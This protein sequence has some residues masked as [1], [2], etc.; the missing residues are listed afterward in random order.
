MKIRMHIGLILYLAHGLTLA[1]RAQPYLSDHN[2]WTNSRTWVLGAPPQYFE[3]TY[4]FVSGDSVVNTTVYKKIFRSYRYCAN[5]VWVPGQ[6]SPC[7][8]VPSSPVLA[9]LIREVGPRWYALGS[10]GQDS[11]LYRFDL[12]VGDSVRGNNPPS[13]FVVDTIIT[14]YNQSGRKLFQVRDTFNTNS[15]IS[16]QGILEG[17]GPT[18]GFLS[19]LF[20]Q[21]FE[22]VEELM[23]YSALP[24]PT[25]CPWFYYLGMGQ[26]LEKE[27]MLLYPNPST[28]ELTIRLF[29]ISGPSVVYL[30]DASG[31]ILFE[32]DYSDSELHLDM[33]VY[34]EGLYVVEVKTPDRLIRRK[35]VKQN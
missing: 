24:M 17:I 25:Y 12:A 20:F 9:A 29:D 6:N 8:A 28:R 1:L 14:N 2:I 26:Y 11:L 27:Q 32:R 33:K 23:C 21:P 34:E 15:T 5:L 18:T 3:Y 22:D 35:F 4:Y 13:V 19:R 10:S 7:S 16:G 30:K 31:R